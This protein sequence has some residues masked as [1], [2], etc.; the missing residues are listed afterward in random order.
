M[1]NVK[2]IT[3]ALVREVGQKKTVRK[4]HANETVILMVYAGTI[5]ATVKTD[6][7]V[8]IANTNPVK[9]LAQTME[10]VTKELVNALKAFTDLIAPKD[11]A[12]IIALIMELALVHL[13]SLANV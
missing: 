12:Q 6:F 5:F 4:E 10:F 3:H 11:S 8:N 2:K 13:I 9:T 7:Q 1:E